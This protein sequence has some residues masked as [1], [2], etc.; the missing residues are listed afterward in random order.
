[1]EELHKQKISACT[2]SPPA[3]MCLVPQDHYDNLVAGAYS[4]F[5]TQK[6]KELHDKINEAQSI[7]DKIRND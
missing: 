7:V 6:L 4:K 1:M 2:Y 3:G 5:P